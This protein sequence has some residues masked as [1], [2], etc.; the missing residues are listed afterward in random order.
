MYEKHEILSLPEPEVK[1]SI[2]KDCCK[3]VSRF[4]DF[5]EEKASMTKEEITVKTAQIKKEYTDTMSKKYP[6]YKWGW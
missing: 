1:R 5:L 4:T 6:N 2:H 3:W